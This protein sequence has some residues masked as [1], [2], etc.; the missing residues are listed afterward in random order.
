MARAPLSGASSRKVGTFEEAMNGPAGKM[1]RIS[2][3]TKDIELA[4]GK[5]ENLARRYS[6]AAIEGSW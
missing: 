3:H 5:K 2:G 4:A 6:T 1:L